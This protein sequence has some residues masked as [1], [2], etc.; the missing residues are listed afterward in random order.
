MKQDFQ[1]KSRIYK[2]EQDF[3]DFQDCQDEEDV[4][5][6]MLFILLIL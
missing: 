6:G 1:E 5:A 2:M 3:Q 4:T